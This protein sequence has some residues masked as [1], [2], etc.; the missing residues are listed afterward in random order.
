M[1]SKPDIPLGGVIVPMATPL[2][3][4][5]RVDSDGCRR[6]ARRLVQ[7]GADGIFLGGS[8][9]M[10]PMLADGQWSELV[11]AATSAVD[12]DA[13]V[14]AGIMETSTPRAVERIRM[15]RRLGL[16]R[17][18]VTP[19]F[20]ITLS[21]PAEFLEHFLACADAAGGPIILYNI[22]GCTYST[23][24]I[25]VVEAVAARGLAAG[26]K[27]SSGDADYFRQI[28]R[29][30]REHG[31]PVLQGNEPDIHWSMQ[32]GAAGAVPVCANVAP[33]LYRD[34]VRAARNGGGDRAQHL[35]AGA[36]ALRQSV[37]L[38]EHNWIAGIM[39][40]IRVLGFGSGRVL[41]PLQ[42]VEDPAR[43]ELIRT[44]VA[45]AAAAA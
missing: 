11:W 15:A 26:I 34:L 37:L 5:G 36:N 1:S 30:G 21:R 41:A 43:L 42:R 31:V 4:S 22:P 7:E 27:E 8:A 25:P 19:S 38:G 29:A 33:E 10:G 17:F 2:D 6:L 39:E 13:T 16:R 45:K 12:P 9:G 3:E 18:V 44:A 23:I 32:E 20:Y 14:L 35:Q 24:P 40:A 28:L